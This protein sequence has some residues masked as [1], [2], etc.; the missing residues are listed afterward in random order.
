MAILPFQIYAD[1]DY[2]FLQ[3]GIVDML[4]SR[5][6]SPDKVTIIDPLV[7]AEAMEGT[8]GLSGDSLALLVGAKVKADYV[9]HGSITALGESVSID[10]KMLDVTGAS[11]H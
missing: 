3:K 11:P 2:S 5:L 6:A 4:A 8:Q 9:I 7:T 10:A 1:K